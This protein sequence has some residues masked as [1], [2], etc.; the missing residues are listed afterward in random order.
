MNDYFFGLFEGTVAASKEDFAIHILNSDIARQSLSTYLNLSD[1]DITMLDNVCNLGKSNQTLS[2]I[3]SFLCALLKQRNDNYS[4]MCGRLPNEILSQIFLNVWTRW[5][6]DEEH[7]V[8]VGKFSSSI[9]AIPDSQDAWNS[10][11]NRLTS[12]IVPLW[13]TLSLVCTKWRDIIVDTPTLWTGCL[14]FLIKSERSF[15]RIPFGLELAKRAVGRR[16][17]LDVSLC[18]HRPGQNNH[19]SQWP[20]ID[21]RSPRLLKLAKSLPSFYASAMPHARSLHIEA[22]DIFIQPLLFMKQGLWPELENLTISLQSSYCNTCGDELAMG[23]VFLDTPKLTQVCLIDEYVSD[24]STFPLVPS[25]ALPWEQLTHLT[26]RQS[27]GDPSDVRDV[28][29]SCSNTLQ[30]CEIRMLGW[31]VDHRDRLDEQSRSAL[32]MDSNLVYFPCLT[33]LFLDFNRYTSVTDSDPNDDAAENRVVGHRVNTF[34]APMFDRL[35]LP[36]LRTLH[37]STAVPFIDPAVSGAPLIFNHHSVED[38]GLVQLQERSGFMLDLFEIEY[39]GMGGPQL[40][41]FLSTVPYLETLSVLESMWMSEDNG[42]DDIWMSEDDGDALAPG[43][44]PRKFI[45]LPKLKSLIIQEF[46][47]IHI[48]DDMYE[49]QALMFLNV[50][51]KRCADPSE[52]F[53]L[54]SIAFDIKR[55]STR[56]ILPAPVLLELGNLPKKVE[57]LIGSGL[58]RGSEAVRASFAP[59]HALGPVER[60]A[61]ARILA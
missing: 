50:I 58:L 1:N 19:L 43:T 16:L 48:S 52:D 30:F 15:D 53:G 24:S 14:S 29:W 44:T 11:Y 25:L 28:F 36:A 51:R 55:N 37:I 3:V 13:F 32:N 57:W 18:F 33:D 5:D 26:I 60:N 56:P 47:D 12:G 21:P 42:D 49:W 45:F 38:F 9:S 46:A 40:R 4:W 23:D 7:D 34:I 41:E 20:K 10:P 59:V 8:F 35:V 17:P 2:G 22:R 27:Q 31:D 6:D 54:Q 39:P 61:H